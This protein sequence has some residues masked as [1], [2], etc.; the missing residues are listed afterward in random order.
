MTKP[1]GFEILLASP[2]DRSGL[3]AEI[4]YD[5]KFVALVTQERGTGQ[6]DVETPG[7]DVVQHDVIRQV[8][9]RGFV[10]AIDV[11]CE[12]LSG[13]KESAMVSDL[14]VRVL[15]S[16]Q[17]A[18]LG[19]ITP[20]MRAV[21]VQWSPDRIEI[22]IYTDGEASSETREDFDAAVVTQVVADFSFPE[23]GDPTVDFEFVRCDAPSRLPDW[24][25]SVYHR[26]E[27]NA[28]GG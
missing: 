19:E 4:Y 28:V 13:R 14:H 17:R 15:L 20:E 27:R 2:S 3:V 21:A 8:D 5:G 18:L 1:T 9:A 7:L 22:R 24:G 26:A 6:F 25:H 12:R 11:A 10:A 16:L 23:R